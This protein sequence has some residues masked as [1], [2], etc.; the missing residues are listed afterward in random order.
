MRGVAIS[1]KTLARVAAAGFLLTCFSW[2][3]LAS[4]F[5]LWQRKRSDA[6]LFGTLAKVATNGARE[7]KARDTSDGNQSDKYQKEQT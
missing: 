6:A 1:F 5:P 4:I 7:P 2:L 3:R